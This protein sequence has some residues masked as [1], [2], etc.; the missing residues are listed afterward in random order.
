MKKGFVYLVGAGPGDPELITLKAIKAMEE[1]DCIVYDHLANP[2]LVEKYSCEKIYA[3]KSG[4]IHSISQENIN[5]LL[6][7]KARDGKVIV[8]LKGGDPF[9]FGRGGE[10]AETLAEAKIAFAVVPGVSSFYSAPAYAGIP[11]THRE[12]ANAV[13]VITGYRRG[14]A[15]SGKGINFPEYN[16]DCTF[17]FLMGVKNLPHISKTLIE[18]KN[19]PANTPSAIIS[20]G[21][22]PEQQVITGPLKDISE[23][24]LKE[25]IRPPSVILV[26]SVVSLKEKLSWFE[27]QPLFGKKIVVTRTRE[28]A[29]KLTQRLSAL[30]AAVIEF[31]TI[32]IKPN[33]DRSSLKDALDS[34]DE[35]SWLFFTSQNAV[36]IFFNDLF[37]SGLDTRAL[38]N[39]KI[40]VIGPATGD[41]LKKHGIHPDLIPGEYVAESLLE[42]VK[43][44]N[45]N[46][47]KI[48][49]PCAEE[50][51]STLAEGLQKLGAYVNRIHI[52]KT[53]AP[54]KVDPAVFDKIQQADIVTF[55]SSSTARNFFAL[56]PRTDTVCA[57]IG[58]VTSKTI[59][60]CAHEPLIEASEHTIDGLLRAI[61][62]YYKKDN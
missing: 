24:A 34:I 55:T 46:G 39:L 4:G 44:L 33:K 61:V 1:A 12:H 8:R 10:E 13:Q 59:R 20:R 48:L 29:S 50:A 17:V 31:S 25:K 35:Y 2:A 49:L 38:G 6:I 62:E 60:D 11:V 18:K 22:L 56:Q 19:F 47:K 27:S 40:A 15:L 53:L 7:E 42:A 21:T 52:Y 16:A 23:I 26:G 41:E 30:G 54:E 36:D 32:E 5:T 28:Q 45:L 9:I 58:P 37:D 14:D 3:G 57:S 51:R 43:D